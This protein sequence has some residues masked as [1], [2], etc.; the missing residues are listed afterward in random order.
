V[1]RSD[2]ECHFCAT[3]QGFFRV[4]A[5]AR[6]RRSGFE[7]I[8]LRKSRILSGFSCKVIFSAWLAVFKKRIK[9]SNRLSLFCFEADIFS[10]MSIF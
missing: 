3:R 4:R 2:T 10:E 6:S 7:P 1:S 8:F 5:S 9:G